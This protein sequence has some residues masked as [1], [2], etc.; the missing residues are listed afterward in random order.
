MDIPRSSSIAFL[1]SFLIGLLAVL[2]EGT[3]VLAAMQ[4]TSLAVPIAGMVPGEGRNPQLP[5][6]L[7]VLS[8]VVSDTA[9]AT[10]SSVSLAFTVL[11]L[12]T[13]GQS[14]GVT[15]APGPAVRFALDTYPATPIH[16]TSPVIGETGQILHINMEVSVA[17]DRASGS[18]TAAEARFTPQAP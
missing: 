5:R 11:T 9:L 6:Y 2:A 14:T 12:K 7:Y 4:T 1:L 18:L 17:F 8:N 10:P 13:G 16:F 15:Y 3:P